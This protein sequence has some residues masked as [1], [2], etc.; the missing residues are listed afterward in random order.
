MTCF[1]KKIFL[2]LGLI[3]LIVS[4]N[5]CVNPDPQI[6]PKTSKQFSTGNELEE[7]ILKYNDG[8]EWLYINQI[9][10]QNDTIN[11][12]DLGY[13][14]RFDEEK[15]G[16]YVNP[17]I[18]I[19]FSLYSQS[20]GNDT[21]PGLY[22]PYHSISF[23]FHLRY[24]DEINEL[25]YTFNEYNS[26]KYMYNYVVYIYSDNTQIGE[27]YYYEKLNISEDWIIS[28]LNENIKIKR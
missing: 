12:Y 13:S 21:D 1:F 5:C 2:I 25:N 15:N 27:V 3:F 24:C 8:K 26:D 17:F 23:L 7:F 18:Q 11:V 22:V 28:F 4:L 10:K 14:F 19:G 9:G 6:A 16:A 20:L